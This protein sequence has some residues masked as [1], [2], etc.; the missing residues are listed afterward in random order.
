MG[1]VTTGIL[2]RSSDAVAIIGLADGRVLDINEA[3][4]TVTGHTRRELVGRPARDL[5]VGLGQAAGSTPFEALQGL[6]R[7][8]MPR[9]AYGPGRGSCVSPTCRRSCSS[10]RASMVRSARFAACGI[11]RLGSDVRRQGR[12]SSTSWEAATRVRRRRPGPSRPLVDACDGT[13][14]PL[15]RWSAHGGP[16]PRRHLALSAAGSRTLPGDPRYATFPPRAEALRRTW[17]RGEPTWI[18]DALARSE[19]PQAPV[20]CGEPMHG[21]LGFPAL[22]SGRVIGVVEFISRETRQPDA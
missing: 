2:R 6:D 17:L 4:F 21:W 7:L 5:L 3:L 19:L 15:A 22:R 14:G 8:T 20:A 11:P 16:S 10:S 1:H 9:S 13:W 18:P 12:S